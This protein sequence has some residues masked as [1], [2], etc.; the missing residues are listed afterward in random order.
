MARATTKRS[1]AQ[2]APPKDARVE[3][4][5]T[6]NGNDITKP[7]VGELKLPADSR[8]MNASDWGIY[9][10]I[11]LDDQVFSTFQQRRGAVVAKQWD[12]LPGDDK[13]PRSVEAAE[14]MKAN[15]EAIGWDRITD[16]MLYAIFHGCSVAELLW[17][18][19]D[20]LWQWSRI[21]VRHARRFRIDKDD[22]LRLLTPRNVQGTVVPDRKFWFVATGA[23]DDDEPYG[24][25]LAEWLYWP[26]LFKRNGIRFWNVFLDKF[27]TPTAKGTYR[28]GTP[29]EDI[30]KLLATLQAIATDSGFVVPEGMAVELLEVARSGT[31]D[32]ATLVRYMDAAIAKIVLS[33]TMTTDNGS[34]L[35]QAEVHA[36]V[37]LEVI[38]ADA[39]LLSDSFN[40]GPSR[41]WTDYNYGP[42]VAQPQI[43][44]LVEPEEDLKAQAETDEA[45]D[46][47]GWQRTEE[48][49]KDTYGDGYEPKP[50]AD[51]QPENLGHNGGPPLIED[52]EDPVVGDKPKVPKPTKADFASF[53]AGDPR[54]LYVSRKV[55]NAGAIIAWAKGQGLQLDQSADDL[56]V[57][58]AYSR[59]PVDWMSIDGGYGPDDGNLTVPAGGPRLVE[60]F[61]DGGPV[62]LLFSC[63]ALRW[64]HEQIREAGASWDHPQYRPHITLTYEPTDID[65]AAVEPFQGPIVL[66]PEIFEP[67]DEDQGEKP[68]WVS[69]DFGAPNAD[70]DIV[71]MAVAQIMSD[72]GFTE[73]PEQ[74]VNTLANALQA[75]G[76][77]DEARAILKRGLD[78]INDAPMARELEAVSFAVQLAAR[79]GV[80][81]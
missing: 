28:P 31:A 52:D 65:L 7:W 58:I 13:D 20:G 23:S 30:A 79:S 27:G 39:D 70:R 38:K 45:L 35:S 11:L 43:I 26:S 46:R 12:V 6:G 81:G 64:R 34:S 19:K 76:S 53:A 69:V 3:I 22:R 9:E 15:L 14:K 72:E 5:T 25:G 51:P 77:E 66:G 62:V 36:D 2:S 48:S 75:A 42:D 18:M 10:R 78:L 24:R 54:T 4:A 49:F 44:R 41:W 61:N 32:F 56:H 60:R 63:S 80:D 1:I 21:K 59:R 40:Q 71:D 29:K 16:K 17:E 47:L 74:L 57:T 33:Q 68:S 73:V 8:L 55:L 50:K 67:L 37:K